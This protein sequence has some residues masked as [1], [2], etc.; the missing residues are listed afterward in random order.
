MSFTRYHDDP[1][2]IKKQVEMMTANSRYIHDT[3][4]WGTQPGYV[5]DPHIR[6]QTWAGNLWDNAIDVEQYL[7]GNNVPLTKGDISTNK[8]PPT[9]PFFQTIYPTLGANDM[10]TAQSRVT[11]PAWEFCE[12]PQFRPAYLEHNPQARIEIPF[13][14]NADTRLAEKDAYNKSTQNMQCF[15]LPPSTN[16]GSLLPVTYSAR[17]ITSTI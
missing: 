15:N 4:G 6:A 14:H 3:P 13:M 16:L 1:A 5:A 12:A 2:R 7:R 10:T 11:H 9:Q 8:L 17:P